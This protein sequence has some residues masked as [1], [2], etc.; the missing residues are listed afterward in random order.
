MKRT[1]LVV[2]DEPDVVGLVSSNLKTA[3]FAVITAADGT[4][5]LEKARE[6]K[7]DLVIL[8]VML[9]E[10]SGLDVCRAI[11]TNPELSATP[12]IMLTAKAD[13]I[14]QVVGLEIGADDYITKPFSPRVLVSRVQAILRRLAKARSSERIEQVEEKGKV[15]TTGPISLHYDRREVRVGGKLVECSPT[16][17]KLLAA[18]VERAGKV[19][20]REQLLNRVW[21]YDS[22]TGTRTVD[23]HVLRLREKLGREADRLETVR[24]FGYRIASLSSNQ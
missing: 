17:F 13:E 9:P 16:E 23:M 11:R 8:D 5:A 20:S 2:D 18:L 3:G 6:E 14:D 7:P 21:G 1:I 15:L 10:M 24:G 12:I 19:L 4:E 22:E